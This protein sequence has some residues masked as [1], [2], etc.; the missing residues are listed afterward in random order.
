MTSS[1]KLSHELPPDTWLNLSDEVILRPRHGTALSVPQVLINEAPSSRGAWRLKALLDTDGHTVTGRFIV[2]RPH[3]DR[4]IPLEFIWAVCNS[5]IAN[6]FAFSH[7]GKRH[8]DAGM[9]RDIPFPKLSKPAVQA[10]ATAAIRYLEY[11]RS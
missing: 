1:L 8:N 10:V 3:R 2:I 9:L 5:P 4:A 11:V 7:S 6:A